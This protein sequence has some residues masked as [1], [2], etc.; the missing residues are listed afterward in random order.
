MLNIDPRVYLELERARFGLTNDSAR[1][2]DLK[3]R[4]EQ[5][6]SQIPLHFFDTQKLLHRSLHLPDVK[7]LIL[8]T[9]APPRLR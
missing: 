8:R 5:G 9:R 3:K 7:S 4:L 2:A 6:V 1:L